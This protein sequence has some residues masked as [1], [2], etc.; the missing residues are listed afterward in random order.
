SST[1]PTKVTSFTTAELS[2]SNTTRRTITSTNIAT[3]ISNTSSS[4][5]A[6]CS[7]GAGFG[8]GST[9][10]VDSSS[11]GYLCVRFYYYGKEPMT[12]NTT[13]QLQIKGM[14]NNQTAFQGQGNRAFDG[15]SN[16][17]ITSTPANVTIGGP[18][19]VGEGTLVVYGIVGKLGMNGTYALDLGWIGPEIQNC[20]VE[21]NLVSG[22]G[23]PDYTFENGCIAMSTSSSTGGVSGN[24]N[25]T[26]DMNPYPSGLV[27]VVPAGATNS[28]T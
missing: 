10:R 7:S 19:N 15:S 11:P 27:V 9:L 8:I 3:E 13:S 25:T 28:E 17:T 2:Q 12:I 5:I 22:N 26:T 1:A 24:S 16:F 14:E 21:F 4:A 20:G 23:I 18:S 6:A